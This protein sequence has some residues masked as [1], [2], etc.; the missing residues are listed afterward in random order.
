MTLFDEPVKERNAVAQL[1]QD[2][3]LKG[4]GDGWSDVLSGADD[5][6]HGI[7]TKLLQERGV[8]CPA[9]GEVFNAFREC[10]YSVVKVVWVLQDPYHQVFGNTRV[11]DG[12]AM[13]CSH[14]G[15]LQP[16]LKLVY[17]EIERTVGS[18]SRDPDLRCWANQGVL[19]MN[20]ALTVR[21]AAPGSHTEIW[22]PFTQYLLRELGRRS[23]QLI[24][25]F[26]GANARSFSTFA[27]GTKF[28][29]THPASAAYRG[30]RWDCDDVFNS[31]NEQLVLRKH[32][33]IEW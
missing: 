11:A 27:T 18:T 17:D 30:G 8:V 3:M 19:L 22:R 25:I 23:S 31:V 29:V 28:M 13:S 5:I 32:N 24:Y 15:I 21:Q 12:I 2:R 33:K 14:T 26:A 10:K 9:G 4:I 20:T 1:L 16:S 6:L 7:C